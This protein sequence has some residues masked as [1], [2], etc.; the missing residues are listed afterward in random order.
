MCSERQGQR[1]PSMTRW[2]QLCGR[3]EVR[4]R[5]LDG[6]PSSPLHQTNFQYNQKH[7]SIDSSL[8]VMGSYYYQCYYIGT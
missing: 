2:S 3:H 4:L 6:P 8:Q 5:S 1:I 7:K